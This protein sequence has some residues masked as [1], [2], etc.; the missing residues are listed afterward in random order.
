MF[1]RLLRLQCNILF[2][3]LEVALAQFTPL[4]LNHDMARV[5]FA[6][7]AMI[8]HN[9]MDHWPLFMVRTWNNNICCMS[10]YILY[11]VSIAQIV[12][13]TDHCCL[14]KL[15][16]KVNLHNSSY[17]LGK[18]NYACMKLSIGVSCL[19]VEVVYFFASAPRLWCNLR[20]VLVVIARCN[21]KF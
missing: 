12:W 18:F 9:D 3:M 14:L 8:T 16:L 21:S 5:E 10:C 19:I 7:L 6:F 11:G 13:K 20:K 4:N 15:S 17:A 2:V 1:T